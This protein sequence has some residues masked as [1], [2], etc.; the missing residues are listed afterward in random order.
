M[1]GT[2]PLFL[3]SN[4][5][6]LPFLSV[7]HPPLLPFQTL[8]S[9][10]SFPSLLAL[11]FIQFNFKLCTG[12]QAK[13]VA[14]WLPGTKPSHYTANWFWPA[15]TSAAYLPPPH[16]V[17]HLC[18]PDCLQQRRFQNTQEGKRQ[19]ASLCI[20]QSQ[21]ASMHKLRAQTNK[22]HAHFQKCRNDVWG[23]KYALY[24]LVIT[25][26]YIPILSTVCTSI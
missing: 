3:I 6:L 4:P 5:P 8:I 1:Q 20:Q 2:S 24:L 7:Y 18:T 10:P 19:T 22:S 15:A 26:M 23:P 13:R 9:L 17:H 14:P 12:R 25:L 21:L 11:S 16:T